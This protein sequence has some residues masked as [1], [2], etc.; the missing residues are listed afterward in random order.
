MFFSKKKGCV[1]SI[2]IILYGVLISRSFT[3]TNVPSDLGAMDWERHAIRQSVPCGN[4]LSA[5]LKR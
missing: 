4:A 2:S 5:V 3:L 1:L